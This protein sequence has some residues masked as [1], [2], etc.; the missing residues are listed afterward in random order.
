MDLVY[1]V[2]MATKSE[3]VVNIHDAKTHFSELLRRVAAGERVIIARAGAPVAVL[4]PLEAAPPRV[5]VPGIDRGK[6][7]IGPDWDDP[8]PGFEDIT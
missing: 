8:I 2:D 1:Y 5:R 4:G 6:V 3:T 7:L